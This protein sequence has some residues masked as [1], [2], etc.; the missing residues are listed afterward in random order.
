MR[1]VLALLLILASVY[2]A[3]AQVQRIPPE[4]GSP[5]GQPS[6][7]DSGQGLLTSEGFWVC[8]DSGTLTT[9]QQAFDNS[10]TANIVGATPTKPWCLVNPLNATEKACW[11][12]NPSTGFEHTLPDGERSVRINA[13][14]PW[15]VRNSDGTVAFEILNGSITRLMD[16]SATCNSA[17]AG[18]QRYKVNSSGVAD[19]IQTCTKLPDN[20]YYWVGPPQAIYMSTATTT[21]CE[22]TP[23]ND[24]FWAGLAS[25]A[26]RAAHQSPSRAGYYTDL[27]VRTTSTLASN[28][29]ATFTLE[30]GAADTALACSISNAS[31]CN[32]S[33]VAQVA[34]GDLVNMK[35]AC[36]DGT[37][38]ATK[39]L[40]SLLFYPN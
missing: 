20:N 18:A 37:G 33:A 21:V 13:T 32:S 28:E 34:L 30:N 16:S 27:K 31:L 11:Q 15:R 10:T 35:E 39:G 40:V 17:A 7:C 22:T 19:A 4:G 36:T 3:S 12:W 29:T 1:R 26:T 25:T 6:P 8:G 23:A 14:S 5:I 2:L 24:F 38:A 9:L